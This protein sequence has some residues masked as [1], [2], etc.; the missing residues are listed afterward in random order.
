MCLQATIWKAGGAVVSEAM[1]SGCCVVANR[2]IGAVPFLIEDGVN[3]KSY[4]D[5][6]YEA[7]ERTVLELCAQPEQITAAWK[8]GIPDDYRKMECRMCGA[9]LPGIL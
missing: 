5:G 1:N 6:S 7:F 9:A 2:Q 8:R 3:G 4:P